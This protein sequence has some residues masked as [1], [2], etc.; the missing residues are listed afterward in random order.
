MPE[1]YWE[2]EGWRLL[3]GW[4][5]Y[6]GAVVLFSVTLGPHLTQ[7]WVGLAIIVVLTV[8]VAFVVRRRWFF[9]VPVVMFA[10]RGLTLGSC[11]DCDD[12]PATLAAMTAVVVLAPTLIGVA[13]GLIAA[14]RCALRR[15]G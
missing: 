3:A 14:H 5:G 8:I 9:A 10:I 12:T 15:Q 13:L 11:S 6:P 1:G 7:F 4:L 2:R